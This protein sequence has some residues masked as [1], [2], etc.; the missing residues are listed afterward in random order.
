[1]SCPN[2]RIIICLYKIINI[3][4]LIWFFKGSRVYFW[5]LQSFLW[6]W[7]YLR[8]Y[9]QWSSFHISYNCKGTSWTMNLTWSTLFSYPSC[10]SHWMIASRLSWQS[11][12]SEAVTSKTVFN[13]WLYHG[14][15]G[16]QLIELGG[17]VFKVETH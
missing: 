11:R 17:L 15:Q 2:I 16:P 14:K 10:R 4:I 8:S 9:F 1:M 7:N 5:H 3:W 13:K 12:F 6:F